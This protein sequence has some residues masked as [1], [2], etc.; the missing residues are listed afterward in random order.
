MAWME[1]DYSKNT[2]FRWKVKWRLEHLSALGT[3]SETAPFNMALCL[4]V[5]SCAHWLPV[6]TCTIRNRSEAGYPKVCA[7]VFHV[8]YDEEGHPR[9]HVISL[10]PQI[11]R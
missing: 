11:V 6:D 1:M 4:L 3:M 9:M 7:R 2:Y 8:Q 5:F 10:G